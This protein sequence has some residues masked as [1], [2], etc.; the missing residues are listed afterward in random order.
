VLAKQFKYYHNEN[1]L[2]SVDYV[3]SLDSQIIPYND[4]NEDQNTQPGDVLNHE[5]KDELSL[6]Y[7]VYDG[8]STDYISNCRNVDP[9]AK[10]M[11]AFLNMDALHVL[12]SECAAVWETGMAILTITKERDGE[13]GR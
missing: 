8:N 11:Y 10:D 7:S 9:S 4:D 2:W 13:R 6:D 12:I 3:R 1:A 5:Y